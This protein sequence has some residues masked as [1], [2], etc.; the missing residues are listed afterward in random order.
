[1]E[2]LDW[3]CDFGGIVLLG[4]G[5]LFDYIIGGKFG[6]YIYIEV[7][8]NNNKIV[9]FFSLFLRVFIIVCV[10]FWYYMYGVNVNRINLRLKYGGVFG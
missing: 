5:F 3:I 1:M 10:N 8:V 6:Y 4:I 9:R 2:N 7:S